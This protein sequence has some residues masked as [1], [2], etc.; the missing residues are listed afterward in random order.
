MAAGRMKL[1]LAA[2][3]CAGESGNDH[4]G[5]KIDNQHH[6]HHHAISFIYHRQHNS[7]SFNTFGLLDISSESA[8][9]LPFHM[10]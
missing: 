9:L 5:H 4:H 1:V 3:L 6:H 7:R 2:A 10:L 8:C